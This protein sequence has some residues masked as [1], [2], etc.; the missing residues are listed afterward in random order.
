MKKV[1]VLENH[2]DML[3]VLMWQMELMGYSIIAARHGK[4]G[5]EKALEEKPQLILMDIIMPVMDGR[6]A[7]RMNRAN[8][9]THNIP[10]L[11]A[12][13][14]FW[15]SDLR[16]FLEARCNDII[17]KPFRFLSGGAWKHSQRP[18]C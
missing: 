14:L 2:P 11:A 13:V 12:T 3:E 15:D 17:T 8:P 6:E 4:E 5:V 10:V 1:L 18:K 9:E 16:S 7:T